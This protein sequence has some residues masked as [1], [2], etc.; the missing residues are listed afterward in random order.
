LEGCEPVP[1]APA[2]SLF[3]LRP[4][5][6]LADIQQYSW[7]AVGQDLV[8]DSLVYYLRNSKLKFSDS[9]F[10]EE[11]AVEASLF[12]AMEGRLEDM[13]SGWQT[14]CVLLRG[15]NS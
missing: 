14:I 15:R 10:E 11:E 7:V 8:V 9:E 1:E 13:R 6:R 2:D 3:D 5:V 12:Q 4:W